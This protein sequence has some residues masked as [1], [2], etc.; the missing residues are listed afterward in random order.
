MQKESIT[1]DRVKTERAKLARM[2]DDFF[3]GLARIVSSNS[4]ANAST[5]Q[6][7]SQP[8]NPLT[9]ELTIVISFPFWDVRGTQSYFTEIYE[10]LEKHRFC[11]TPLLPS[12]LNLLTPK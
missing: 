4:L 10:I 12:E 8:T 7:T 3:G 9:P 11:V 2:Y 6:P 5:S 1:T